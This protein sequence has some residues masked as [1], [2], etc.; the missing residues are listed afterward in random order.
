MA[1][2]ATRSQLTNPNGTESSIDITGSDQTG[3]IYSGALNITSIPK[4]NDT[5]GFYI[6]PLTSGTMR[7]QLSNQEDGEYFN[8]QSATLDAYLGTWIPMKIKKVISVTTAT[9]QIGW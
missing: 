7:V 2:N 8:L 6:L 1:N 5:G 4:A 3:Q 9:Y